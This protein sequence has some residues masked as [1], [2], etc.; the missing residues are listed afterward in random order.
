M[1]SGGLKGRAA[2]SAA[3]LEFLATSAVTRIVST[4]AGLRPLNRLISLYFAFPE[5]PPSIPLAECGDLSVLHLFLTF[6]DPIVRFELDRAL[7][8][9]I[10]ATFRGEDLQ[11]EPFGTPRPFLKFLFVDPGSLR[12]IEGMEEITD[13]T[14]GKSRIATPHHLFGSVGPSITSVERLT[15]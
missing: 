8:L 1:G 9:A 13:L 15:T 6:L 12:R 7:T 4:D 3:L 2:L 5:E 10:F 14:D 11:S